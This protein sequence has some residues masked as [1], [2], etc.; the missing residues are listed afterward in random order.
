[1]RRLLSASHEEPYQSKRFSNSKIL[2]K[3]NTVPLVIETK[4]SSHSHSR[5]AIWL[6]SSTHNVQLV[7]PVTM[8]LRGEESLVPGVLSPLVG[9]YCPLLLVH[10]HALV[11]FPI[12]SGHQDVS[13]LDAFSKGLLDT[14]TVSNSL[15]N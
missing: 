6:R 9:C 13:A 3:D 15:T 1:M 7:G 14:C 4:S 11:L 8:S 5:S 2:R 12:S 10:L